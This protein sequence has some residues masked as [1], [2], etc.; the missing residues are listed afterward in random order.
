VPDGGRGNPRLRVVSYNVHGLRDDL[1]ALTAVVRE[2]A[3]DVL[4]IQEAP[5]RVRWRTRCAELARRFGMVYAAGGGPALGN[6]IV[7]NLRIA[8]LGAW[9]LRYPL[10]PGRHLRGAAFARCAVDRARFVVAGTHLSLD[11]AERLAQ[12][13]LLAGALAGAGASE[14]PSGAAGPVVLG[15]D[16]NEPPGAPARRLL[17][18]GRVDPAGGDESPTFP[19]AGGRERIDG[20]LV[21]PAVEVTGYRVV[22]SALVVHASDHRPVVADLRIPR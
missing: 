17:S 13:G 4:L 1:G 8:V 11:G 18:A 9:T 5:R 12:A 15:A 3:P 6:L 19:A 21:D 7:V 14:V 16:F 2:L 22:D 10:V 20:M